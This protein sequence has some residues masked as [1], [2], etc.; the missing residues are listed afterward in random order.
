MSS[1]NGIGT[2]FYRECDFGDDGTYVATYWLIFAYVPLIPLYS[3]RMHSV[4]TPNWSLT[5]HKAV[6]L[7][8]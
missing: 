4:H 1:I 3:A 2:N 6:P 5:T 7:S 8:E